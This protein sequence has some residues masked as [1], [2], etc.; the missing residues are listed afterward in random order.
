MNIDRRTVVAGAAAM[1]AASTLQ[2]ACAAPNAAASGVRYA[3][4]GGVKIGHG[5]FNADGAPVLF[6]PGFATPGRAWAESAKYYAD[7]GLKV[8]WLDNRGVDSSDKPD[9]D[10]YTVEQMAVDAIAV[11]DEL[12]WDSAHIWGASLGGQIA[13]IMAR[14][15]PQR[16]KSLII[17]SSTAGVPGVTDEMRELMQDLDA[18]ESDEDPQAAATQQFVVLYGAKRLEQHPDRLQAMVDFR[19]SETDIR[20]PKTVETFADWTSKDWLGGVNMRTLIVH[21]IEDALFPLE[22]AIEMQKMLPNADLLALNAPH[23][24]DIVDDGAAHATI[25]TWIARTDT[26]LK[27]G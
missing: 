1:A 5:L 21:G 10:S 13:Q 16:I 9:D 14:D 6:I 24:F 11:L 15:N 23:G 19:T 2:T 22:N 7:A 18:G 27:Q 26:L 12:G 25:A 3:N 8:A 4:S 20:L 17:A